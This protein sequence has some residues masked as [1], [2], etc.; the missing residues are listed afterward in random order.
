MDQ[1]TLSME[2][3][4]ELKNSKIK[5]FSPGKIGRVAALNYGVSM[6]SGDYIAILDADDRFLENK[7]EIQSKLLDQDHS[8][9]LAYCNVIFTN[10]Y[11]RKLKTSNYPSEHLKIF[12]YLKNLNPFPASSAMFRRKS[13]DKINGY[14]NRCEKSIDFNLYLALA[15]AGSKFRGI[16]RPLNVIRIDDTTWGKSDNQSLQLKFGMLGLFNYYLVK[17]KN[18]SLYEI[19]DTEWQDLMIKFNEWFDKRLFHKKNL[20]KKNLHIS[21]EKLRNGNFFDAIYYLLLSLNEDKMTLFHKG[22]G[23]NYNQD[24]IDFFDYIKK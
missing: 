5:V 23:F 20:S 3:I 7:L 13:F 6:S 22:I 8:I 15:L 18:I 21:F 14:N 12:Q 1:Q 24:S 19:S 4:K 16:T 9:C 17:N 11:G 10:K 2:M